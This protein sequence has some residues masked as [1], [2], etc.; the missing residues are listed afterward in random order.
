MPFP[1]AIP[2]DYDALAKQ[3]GGTSTERPPWE[4]YGPAT[5]PMPGFGGTPIERPPWEDYDAL[6]AKHGGAPA[7]QDPQSKTA[8]GRTIDEFA[9]RFALMHPIDTLKGMGNAVMHPLDTFEA[10]SHQTGDL[11]R[12]AQESYR[13]GDYGGA[14]AHAFNA[15]LN[16]I[17]GLGAALDEAATKGANGDWAGLVGDAAA[18]AANLATPG[19]LAE[20]AEMAGP[21]L[22][23]AG[24]AARDVALDVA[25]N[26]HVGKA[27]GA[28][29]GAAAGHATG[30]PGAGWAGVWAGKELGEA[31]SE[32]VGRLKQKLNVPHVE[33]DI[34][35]T[36]PETPSATTAAASEAK[37]SPADA[38]RETLSEDLASWLHS[39]GKGIPHDAALKMSPSDWQLARSAVRPGKAQPVSPST[40][41]LTLDKLA[42]KWAASD[43]A[44]LPQPGE[45]LT[46]AQR[47]I[48]QRLA[49]EMAK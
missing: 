4:D 23:K 3:H 33:P 49:V 47:D 38:N 41:K 12:K 40:V 8:V 9:N 7:Q 20:G 28:A 24:T 36:A 27:V 11:A 2:V 16:T 17:P 15:A 19:K 6:A 30:I 29:A 31:A 32:Y 48:A 25:S 42:N 18:A 46:P 13:Q 1:G 37:P 14:A 45:N 5:Q 21:L 43:A 26:P 39:D 44:E 22:S 10:I 35:E 34:P